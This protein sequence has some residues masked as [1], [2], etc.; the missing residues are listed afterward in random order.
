MQCANQDLNR[1]RQPNV[2]LLPATERRYPGNPGL[3]HPV[4]FNLVHDLV[5][6]VAAQLSGPQ[7]CEIAQLHQNAGRIAEQGKDDDAIV[8][9]VVET[10]QCVMTGAMAVVAARHA[11]CARPGM[12]DTEPRARQI[13]SGRTLVS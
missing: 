8:A 9:A 10:G 13:E 4:Q 11:N 2:L 3:K 12:S 6:E 1:L 5:H 7:G